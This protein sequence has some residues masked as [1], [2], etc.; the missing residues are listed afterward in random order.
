MLSVFNDLIYLSHLL[1]LSFTLI[2]GTN[3]GKWIVVL[4]NPNF[5]PS[6]SSDGNIY[7]KDQIPYIHRMRKRRYYTPLEVEKFKYLQHKPLN[8]FGLTCALLA[9]ATAYIV[10]ERIW[11]V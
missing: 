4:T 5:F 2:N 3:T 1:D 7:F 11:I 9:G 8:F 6:D 10:F